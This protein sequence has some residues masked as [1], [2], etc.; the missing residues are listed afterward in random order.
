MIPAARCS[1]GQSRSPTDVKLF[2]CCHVN[3][4]DILQEVCVRTGGLKTCGRAAGV[5]AP[6]KLSTC[7][8]RKV[9]PTPHSPSRASYSAFAHASFT[10]C[11]LGATARRICRGVIRPAG[12]KR[13]CYRAAKHRRNN[14]RTYNIRDIGLD[15]NSQ[16]T[17]RHI[18]E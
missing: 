1:A 5:R 6:V 4:R 13:G 7:Q 12:D 8:W 14:M 15:H 18:L 11:F 17:P 16:K 9:K 2:A 10:S 3:E